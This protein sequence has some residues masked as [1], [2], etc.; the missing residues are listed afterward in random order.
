[1]SGDVLHPLRAWRERQLPRLTLDAAAA[2]VGTVRQVWFDWERGRRIPS[3]RFMTAIWRFTRAQ[4]VPNDFYDL[5]PIG[6]MSLPL[7]DAPAPLF[8]HANAAVGDGND[9]AAANERSDCASAALQ[10]AA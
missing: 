6:Q 5:P 4:V 3:A 2:A 9:E 8:D 7:G 10:A 1:V